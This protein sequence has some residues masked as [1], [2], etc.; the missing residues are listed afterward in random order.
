MTD[1]NLPARL[2]LPRPGETG[3]TTGRSRPSGSRW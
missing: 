3:R 1:D 2:V